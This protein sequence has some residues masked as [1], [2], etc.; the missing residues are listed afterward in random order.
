[1]TGTPSTGWLMVSCG[2]TVEAGFWLG[3]SWCAGTCSEKENNTSS[4]AH[5][6]YVYSGTPLNGHL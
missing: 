2:D 5:R 3:S 1:M 4:L 6:Y